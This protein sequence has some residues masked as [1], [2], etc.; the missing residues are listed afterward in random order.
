MK[1]YEESLIDNISI[2]R[3]IKYFKLGIKNPNYIIIANYKNKIF[4]F[5]CYLLPNKIEIENLIVAYLYTINE[6]SL[7]EFIDKRI[8]FSIKEICTFQ[9]LN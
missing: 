4:K 3:H 8:N 6:C 5:G 9:N 7:F 2:F 1:C